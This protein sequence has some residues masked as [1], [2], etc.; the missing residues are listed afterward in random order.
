MPK[1][2]IDVPGS[3]TFEVES[4]TDL[5]DAQAYQAVMGQIRNTPK[6]QGGIMG[7]LKQALKPMVHKLK[8]VL[9][10]RLAKKLLTKLL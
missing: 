1:Y 5:S 8:Q 10:G 3:G 4:P 7:A 9:Q 2:Q 6:P